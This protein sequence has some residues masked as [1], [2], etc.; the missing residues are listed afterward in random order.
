MCGA[1][2]AESRL[3][4]KVLLGIRL[5]RQEWVHVLAHFRYDEGHQF[6]YQIIPKYFV[7][8]K[9]TI[10]MCPPDMVFIGKLDIASYERQV[11]QKIIAKRTV[12]V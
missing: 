5:R 4:G 6:I 2:K 12:I 9:T 11:L 10:Y 1:N 7:V 8:V 3:P